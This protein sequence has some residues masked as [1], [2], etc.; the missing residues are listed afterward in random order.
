MEENI[1]ND[2]KQLAI[3]IADRYILM[4]ECDEGYDYTIFDENYKELD[5]G[6]YDN[7]DIAIQDA[8]KEIIDDLQ[9]PRYS[10]I[11]HEYYRDEYLQG[12]VTAMTP[13]EK[14]D[15]DELEEMTSEVALTLT[16]QGVAEFNEQDIDV[17]ADFRAKTDELFHNLG[18]QNADSIEKTVAAYVQSQIDEYDIDAQIVDV[19]VSGSRCRGLEHDYSD[20]DVVVEYTG[21]IREDN[22]FDMLHEDGLYIGGVSVD[23][24]PIT[25]GKTGTLETYLPTVEAYLQEKATEMG[26]EYGTTGHDVQKSEPEVTTGHNVQKSEPE[27][28]TGHNVQKSEPAET[29]H[30][31]FTVAECSEYHNLGE[32]YEG[33]ETIEDAIEKYNRID[34]KRMY[35]IPSIGIT[36]HVEGHEEWEDDQVDIIIGNRI[37]IDSLNYLPELRDTDKVQEAVK[38]LIEAYPNKEIIDIETQA[39]QQV[40]TGHDVQKSEPEDTTGHNV[41][42]PE[43]EDTT[44][45]NVQKS[46]Q[47]AKEYA[48]KQAE[49]KPLAKIEELE[50][51]NYNMID[52][53]PNNGFEKHKREEEK[54]KDSKKARPSLRERLAAK[55]REIAQGKCQPPEMDRGNEKER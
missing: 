3:H 43:P 15:Y 32:F 18:D 40:T 46:E 31:T 45:H 8:M 47:Q 21:G 11:T 9:R 1:L 42:K 20:V 51:Q 48:E 17:V 19:V 23:I 53:V 4:H 10:N 26:V 33:I 12:N 54:K 5:G 24:N 27:V 13:P 14:V 16:E 30:I 49:Y 38:K 7:P 55:K 50:E 2:E 52:N 6:V 36:M 22:F 28:T 41:Q 44:G 25:E 29:L 34:P 39:Q 37:D 35:G